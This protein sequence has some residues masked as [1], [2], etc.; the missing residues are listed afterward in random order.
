MSVS[1]LQEQTP[2][3][4]PSEGMKAVVVNYSPVAKERLEAVRQA[5]LVAAQYYDLVNMYEAKY[6]KSRDFS[7]A[8]T[9]IQE[10]SMWLTRGLTNP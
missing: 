4:D 5:K 7:L 6:G 8:L 1:T 9:K 3:E 10:A 2:V